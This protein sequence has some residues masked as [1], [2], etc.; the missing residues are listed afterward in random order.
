MAAT[1][2]LMLSFSSG[3]VCGL[4][5]YTLLFKCPQRR[6]RNFL[7]GRL[8]STVYKS[9]PHTIQ[10]LKDTSHAAAAIKITM[11]HCVYLNM[12]TARLLTNCSDTLRNIRTNTRQ[13]ITRTRA[14]RKADYFFVAHSILSVAAQRDIQF[15]NSHSP[16]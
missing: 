8:K 15:Y 3:I 9:N 1:A 16:N 4:D 10:E 2:W 5:S 13:N 11:L 14:K 7:W 12:A 6:G